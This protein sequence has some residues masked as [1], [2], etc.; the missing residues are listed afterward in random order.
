MMLSMIAN[1]RKKRF[2]ISDK[3]YG[4]SDTSAV[5]I[6]SAYRSSPEKEIRSSDG[7]ISKPCAFSGSLTRY[8]HAPSSI[9][10]YANWTFPRGVAAEPDRS[11][12]SIKCGRITMMPFSC[13]IPASVCMNVYSGSALHAWHSLRGWCGSSG[14]VVLP[15]SLRLI[16]ASKSQ[17]SCSSI[18]AF[19]S[20]RNHS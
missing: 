13:R 14:Q 12:K 20:A 5:C 16:Q 4:I 15:R 19:S 10:L 8:C 17:R 9:R 3:K 6:Y 18:P 2:M 1:H 11:G 7:V